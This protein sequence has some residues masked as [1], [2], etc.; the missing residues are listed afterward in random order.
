MFGWSLYPQSECKHHK[1]YI[2]VLYVVS[3]N[4]LRQQTNFYLFLYWCGLLRFRKKYRL[5]LQ[6]WA[7]LIWC[8]Q[9]VAHFKHTLTI[10]VQSAHSWHLRWFETVPPNVLN[11][12]LHVMHRSSIV[13][14]IWWKPNA[15]RCYFLTLEYKFNYVSWTNIN[16]F[17]LDSQG[18][19]WHFFPNFTTWRNVP[20]TLRQWQFSVTAL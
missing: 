7:D 11:N 10:R 17:F 18:Q 12:T 5:E 16:N 8:I 9:F 2:S 3:I 19:E 13:S 15:G 1:V 14:G 20:S 4:A 6:K